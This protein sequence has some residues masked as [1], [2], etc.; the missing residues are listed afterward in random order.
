MQ[1]L[2]ELC[3][4]ATPLSAA[5]ASTP[6]SGSKTST[7][8]SPGEDDEMDEEDVDSN[9][10]W[11][12]P[13]PRVALTIE[14]L[15]ISAP[16]PAGPVAI[17]Q[18]VTA[19]VQ[20]G[21]VLAIMGG[22]GAGK[23]TLLDAVALELRG[24]DKRHG[25][26]RLNG[27]ELTKRKFQRACAYVAQD[28]V[29]WSTLT[30]R[31]TMDFAIGLYQSRK[32]LIQQANLVEYLLRETGL[33]ACQDVRVGNGS[34]IKGIS[35]GQRRRLSV[36]IELLK[37]PAVLV[38]DEPTSGLDS[39]AAEAIFNIITRFAKESEIAVVCTIH[40]PSSY[41]F[42]QFD[43]LLLL[44]TGRMCYFGPAADSSM[45]FSAIGYPSVAGVNP[46]EFLLRIT[47]VD[48]CSVSQ[49]EYIC[50]AWETRKQDIQVSVEKISEELSTMTQPRGCRAG[51]VQQVRSI[52]SRALRGHLRNPIAFGGRLALSSAL[53]AL[54]CFAYTGARERTQKQVLDRLWALNWVLQLPAFLCV[55]AV[56]NF[57]CEYACYRKEVKN[58]MY[59][60]LAYLLADTCVNV[61]V[62]FLL[63]LVS[64]LTGFLIL[65]FNWGHY[66][67]M[68][69]LI[70]CYVG[71]SDTFA[72]LCGTL[73]SNVALGTMFFILQTIM[74]MI[75]NGTLLTQTE[76]VSP[77]LRWLFYAV[78]SKYCFRSSVLLEFD[79]S[80]FSGFGECSNP[81]VPVAQRV[82][83]PCYGSEGIDVVNA[84][85]GTL[86]PVLST[87]NTLAFDLG[88][89][90]GQL[91]V[92]K[93][94]HALV[95]TLKA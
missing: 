54:V 56:P 40:Q 53:V 36:A 39:A 3:Q 9:N 71:W 87:E 24:R 95:L 41:L 7:T 8:E 68:W 75:F 26:V 57:A 44:A 4:S 20:S 69:L 89:I 12:P 46:A 2:V 14:D 90:V 73:F 70:S 79:G 45:H 29:L 27:K 62:W 86:F 19:Y 76:S 13:P 74:N 58:G 92:L 91:A 65:D 34:L 16:T 47:N 67:E 5:E 83:M 64:S 23:T 33:S 35:G 17:L 30:V 18:G 48:F 55:G 21:G 82:R 77:M 84:L 80:V 52:V 93:L 11:L 15:H 22:S 85:S 31:E 60:P 63:S 1:G 78:P 66:L 28:D 94:V 42:H 10:D 88:V 49:V 59:Q 6:T 38:L 72:Q 51:H 50:N 43:M 25:H 61:P 81:T 32:S 37:R